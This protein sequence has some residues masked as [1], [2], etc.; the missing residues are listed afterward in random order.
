[1]EQIRLFLMLLLEICGT[2]LVVVGPIVLIRTARRRNDEKRRALGLP[3]QKRRTSAAAI[4]LL[5][6]FLAGGCVMLSSILNML[7]RDKLEAANLNAKQVY[8]AAAQFAEECGEKGLPAP[9]TQIGQLPDERSALGAFLTKSLGGNLSGGWYAV[10]IED[11]EV[12]L[13]LYSGHELTPADLHKPDA[14]AQH[15][16]LLSPL[17][18]AKDAIGCYAPP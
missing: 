12:Q 13:A 11:G 7:A 1:M 14:D 16:Y 8:G 15:R 4:V 6:L 5:L 2:L 17:T 10:M 18:S 3:P 9:Q